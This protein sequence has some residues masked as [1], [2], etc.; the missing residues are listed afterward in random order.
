[1]PTR[2]RDFRFKFPVGT[3]KAI[4]YGSCIN[5][6]R[7][8]VGTVE[9]K[10]EERNGCFEVRLWKKA[11]EQMLAILNDFND[12]HVSCIIPMHISP[13]THFIEKLHE[14]NQ[15]LDAAY[16]YA[17]V[18]SSK[19]ELV[20]YGNDRDV[21][22]EVFNELRQ[23]IVTKTID[24]PKYACR[25]FTDIIMAKNQGFVEDVHIMNVEDHKSNMYLFGTDSEKFM[26][27]FDEL[28]EKYMFDIPEILVC[29]I[30]NKMKTKLA[31]DNLKLVFCGWKT[32]VYPSGENA[33]EF[34]KEFYNYWDTYKH[35]SI[36]T[37]G[38]DDKRL[39]DI[40]KEVNKTYE[41]KNVF[42]TAKKGKII[43]KGFDEAP[44]KFQALIDKKIK[45]EMELRAGIAANAM[46]VM[47]TQKSAF[48]K[49][50][51]VGFLKKTMA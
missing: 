16:C 26:K 40:C 39:L 27:E 41:E 31:E 21:F 12:N 36:Q 35:V 29:I 5:A 45:D 9:Y 50:T 15:S 49:K 11:A 44:K 42:Y 1:M 14:N 20:V 32:I 33:E 2:N 24:M 43:L 51:N 23:S 28:I 38:F 18:D 47:A 8:V 37:T 19:T 48:V 25:F 17:F 4:A 22:V 10:I 46:K 6:Q 7:I 30:M 3:R 34:Y 13:V